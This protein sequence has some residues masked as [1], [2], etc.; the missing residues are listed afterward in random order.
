VLTIADIPKLLVVSAGLGESVAIVGPGNAPGGSGFYAAGEF[1]LVPNMWVSPRLY[2][3]LLLT[4]TDSSTCG[5]AAPCDVGAKIGFLGAKGRLTFPIPYV[6]PFFELGVGT[7]TSWTSR[8]PT[9]FI[10]ISRRSTARLRSPWRFRSKPPSA[11]LD[12]RR[13][14]DHREGRR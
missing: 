10:R 4:S 8:S 3:G 6:A 7:T 11:F 1:V 2:G 13:L 12:Q 5:G 14:E 9:S